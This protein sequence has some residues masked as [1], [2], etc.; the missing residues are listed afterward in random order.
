[1]I[2]P[3]LAAIAALLLAGAPS[4]ANEADADIVV[5]MYVDVADDGKV[6]AVAPEDGLLPALRDGLVRRAMQWRYAPATWEGRPVAVRQWIALNLEPVA[7]EDG[8]YA[9]RILGTGHKREPGTVMTPPTFPQAA[10]RAATNAALMYQVH[11]SG[12]GSMSPVALLE[13]QNPKGYIKSLD[14]AS[15]QAINSSHRQPPTVAGVSI[16]CDFRMPI[17]FV[18]T[19]KI[20]LPPAD[21]LPPLP[22]QCPKAKLETEVVGMML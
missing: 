9:I 21:S 10:M 20:E 19:R 18:T 13:P 14:K 3:R 4:L 22:N 2:E 8:G 11:V 1:M 6:A 15:R 7:T 16:T 5:G 12:D 17:F